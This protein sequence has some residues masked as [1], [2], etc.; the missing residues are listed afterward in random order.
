MRL[1]SYLSEEIK[2]IKVSIPL[3]ELL[4][5]LGVRNAFIKSLDAFVIGEISTEVNV[6]NRDTQSKEKSKKVEQPSNTNV[7]MYANKKDGPP[8][9]LTIRLC[10][11]NIHN[12]MVDSGASA[13]VMPLGICKTL[14]LTPANLP[15]LLHS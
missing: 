2:K 9:L 6:P 13:N 12:C 4:K 3:C 8:F 7:V 1:M 14:G 10:G 15:K 11:K 5:T